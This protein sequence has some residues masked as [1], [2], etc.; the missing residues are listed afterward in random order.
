MVEVGLLQHEEVRRVPRGIKGVVG[1]AVVRLHRGGAAAAHSLAI[2]PDV[3][4]G[5]RR[6][7]HQQG[8]CRTK[9]TRGCKEFVNVQMGMATQ[10][11]TL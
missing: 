9:V 10:K 5:P 8:V 7:E 1:L 11:Q 6:P 4:H 3:V 2:R